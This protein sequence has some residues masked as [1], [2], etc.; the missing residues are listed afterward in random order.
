MSKLN[1]SEKLTRY[2]TERPDEWTMDEFARDALK[3]EARVS[4]L[5]EIVKAVAHIG[6]EFEDYGKFEIGEY[7]IERAREL[8]SEITPPKAN[9]FI[10]DGYWKD[11]KTE[12]ECYLVK[13]TGDF[14]EGDDSVFYYGLTEAEIKLA[15]EQGMETDLEFV[16]TSYLPVDAA[17]SCGRVLLG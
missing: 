8:L 16:I 7:H 5:T 9:Y 4:E 10:I 6:I 17:Q 2:R 1:L 12:F 3:L 13:D 11:N 15:I 14:G